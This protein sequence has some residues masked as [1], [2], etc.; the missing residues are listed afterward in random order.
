MFSLVL[1][2]ISD[3]TISIYGMRVLYSCTE[4]VFSKI[5]V[6]KANHVGVGCASLSRDQCGCQQNNR[7][8]TFS[9]LYSIDFG[10]RTWTGIPP[11]RLKVSTHIRVLM[12]KVKWI[13]LH[14]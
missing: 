4:F 12:S 6:M 7:S 1:A 8:S 14:N 3:F 5:S 9:H 2:V 11:P 10:I 13:H